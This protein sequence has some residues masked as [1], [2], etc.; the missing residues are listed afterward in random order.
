[1]PVKPGRGSGADRGARPDRAARPPA[2]P[3]GRPEGRPQGSPDRPSRPEHSARPDRGAPPNR[4]ARPEHAVRPDRPSRPNRANRGPTSDARPTFGGLS[5]QSAPRVPRQRRAFSTVGGAVDTGGDAE[6]AR[7]L[8]ALWDVDPGLARALTHGFHAYAGRM[9]PS[10]ARGAINRWSQPGDLVVDPFC[11]SGTVLVEAMGLGRLALGIDA[12]PLGIAIAETRTTLLGEASRAELVAEAMRIAETV[13]DNARKR[14]KPEIP[15]WAKREFTRFFPHVALELFDLRAEVM[16]LPKT[17]VGRALRMCF[18]SNL[19][20][21]MKEGPEAPRDGA[22]KRIARGIPSRLLSD[23]A[24]E[25]ASSLAVLERRMPRGTPVPEVRLGDA[26]D[27]SKIN[28][29]TVSF[30]LSSPPYAGTYDYAA[31][32][33]VRFAW[34]EL[35][36]RSFERTQLGAR[37]LSGDE[38][39]GADPATWRTSTLGWLGEMARI[40]ATGGAMVLV[41]GDG[42]VGDYAEDASATIAEL[43]NEVGLAPIARASQVRATH[44]R[45]LREIFAGQPRREH[46]LLLRKRSARSIK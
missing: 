23:R 33:D 39:F 18:S 2:R 16:A 37:A 28:S 20:K 41:V 31:Q 26:R 9:H 40:L 22:E 4:A 35:P 30:I 36:R 38:G 45:R 1:M 46:L 24:T 32:H 13:S 10:I 8:G 42:V 15:T 7:A 21:L 34:L 5:P 6:E 43:A 27:L 11:G 19:V 12:S 25:L 3:E 29:G 17:P 44:D 14:R